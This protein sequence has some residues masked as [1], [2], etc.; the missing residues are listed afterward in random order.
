MD[1]QRQSARQR[2]GLAF[3]WIFALIKIYTIWWPVDVGIV[4]NGDLYGPFLLERVWAVSGLVFFA[5]MVAM[6]PDW[7]RALGA[8]A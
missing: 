8:K 7:R 4:V 2:I 1:G 5:V 3:L 6:R